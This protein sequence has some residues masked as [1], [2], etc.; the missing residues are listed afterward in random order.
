MTSNMNVWATQIATQIVRDITHSPG[1]YL[2]WQQL[3]AKGA[4][5]PQSLQRRW[6][7]YLT[8]FLL[9]Q[10][11]RRAMLSACLSVNGTPEQKGHA[12]Y[13]WLLKYGYDNKVQHMLQEWVQVYGQSPQ[14]DTSH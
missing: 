2:Y 5:S 7:R 11:L 14:H 12:L 13:E 3:P 6:K 4:K 10:P 1:G 8:T 9:P